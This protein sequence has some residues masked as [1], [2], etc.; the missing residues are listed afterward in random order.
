MKKMVFGLLAIT[1]PMFV[2]WATMNLSHSHL[3]KADSCLHDSIYLKC[4]QDRVVTE[5]GRQS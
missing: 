4:Q 1:L 2:S 5:V 3:V